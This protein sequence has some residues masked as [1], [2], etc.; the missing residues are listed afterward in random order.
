[1]ATA[2]A[3]ALV[4]KLNQTC[5]KSLIEGA[6]GLCM[7]RTNYHIEL[8]HFL[9]KLLELS[10]GDLPRILRHYDIN[11]ST[12][13]RQLTAALDKLKRGNDRAPGLS[14]EVLELIREAW[15]LASVEYHAGKIRSGYLLVAALCTRNLAA[16]LAQSCPELAKLNSDKLLKET[17][18]LV[19]G[20]AEDQFESVE[21]AGA[22]PG[23]PPGQAPAPGSKTPALD[24]FTMDLTDRARKGAIDPV[25]GRDFEIRQ[26][27]DI[28]TRRRQNNPILTG[29]A[30]VG[31]TAVVE[32]FALKIVAGDV[33][34]P[35]RS[36]VL[37]TLDLGLLQAG[38]GVKGEFENRLKSVIQ[39][40]KASPK[41]VILFIDEAHTIIGAGGQAGQGDAANLLK[42]ALARGELRTIA[43]TTWMEYKKYFET[44]AALK[45]RFQVV[46][47]DE[48]DINRAV[49]MMRGLA[50]TLEK[51]HKVRVLDVAVE[52]AVKLSHRY[53]TDRQLPDKSVSLLD[54]ACAKVALSQSAQPPAL[55]DCIRE[56]EHIDVEH[57]ILRRESAAGSDHE[58]RMADL[59][60]KRAGLEKRLAGL[61]ER[62][63]KEKKLA[64]GIS[65]IRK[66]I[67]AHLAA[68]NAAQAAR[69]PEA[70]QS[71]AKPGA[72]K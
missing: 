23:A 15:L 44:D 68:E 20:T 55:Q 53:I 43:A 65:D 58:H 35:L 46:K 14:E 28:L 47:V 36:V 54:T 71:E 70:G 63:E 10:D 57:G 7:A 32:G 2:N 48:P 56:M 22:E 64:A 19:A 40:V 9:L 72:P 5:F 31:K 18:T 51:H 30:G 37:R 27:V 29:E 39:E 38:A 25:I 16:S 60:E 42:P 4:G 66:K 33:P 52:E 3:R 24:Q 34:P 49:R 45:R 67:D 69:A 59:R 12:V 41:P 50:D 8:E 6:A 1:M 61:K 21:Y 26:V 62:W 17:P 13:V 11:Q